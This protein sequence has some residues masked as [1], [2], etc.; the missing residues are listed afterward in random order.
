MKRLL[1]T[2]ILITLVSFGLISCDEPTET[3]HVHTF[4]GE[5]S[6]DENHHWRSSVCGH[7]EEIRAK[8]EHIFDKG[9]VTT[10]PTENS[11]GVK[12]YTCTVC[13]YTKT[14]SISKD[15]MNHEH[16][17]SDSW[18]KDET[19]HWH[20]ATCEHVSKYK[21]KAEHDWDITESDTLI[22]YTCTVCGEVKEEEV[23]IPSDEIIP[24]STITNKLQYIDIEID[25]TYN[26]SSLLSELS[27][28]T[29]SMDD[30]TLAS[31][32]NGVLTG[33]KT[34]V[35]KVTLNHDGK[36]QIVRLE[37]HE[38]GA[39]GSVFT[40]DEYRL[41]GKNIVAFGDSVTDYVTNNA[42]SYYERFADIF[43][44][45]A[46][47]NYAI[48]GTTAHYGYV[49]SNLYNEYFYN[50]SWIT[51]GAGR[52]VVDGP[53]RVKNAYDA[54]E[55]ANIDYV[56][57]AYT[58]NDQHFQP[59]PTHDGYDDYNLNSFD[60]CASF[61]GSYIYMIETLK[62]ANPNVRIILMAPTYA[63][64]DVTGVAHNG[65]NY[66]G[67]EYN[68][69]DYRQ[70]IKEA[71]AETNTKYVNSWNYLKDYFDSHPVNGGSRKYYNDI[72]HLSKTGQQVLAEY[73]A[74][75]MSDWYLQGAFADSATDADYQFSNATSNKVKLNLTITDK[76]LDVPF[77]ISNGST[78][79]NATNLMN[80]E[81]FLTV[82]S[83]NQIAFNAEG[84]YVI[85][86]DSST[87]TIKITKKSDPV[88]YY[89][90]FDSSSSYAKVSAAYLN[91]ETGLYEFD[92]EFIQW[93]SIQINYNGK[94]LSY[95][96]T[97]FQ[98][99]FQTS[100]SGTT[101]SNLYPIQN[102]TTTFVCA[103]LNGGQYTFKYDPKEDTLNIS[104]KAFEEDNSGLTYSGTQKGVAKDNGDGT[105]SF[106]VD[107]P[108]WGS[109]SMKFNNIPLSSAKVQVSGDFT[110]AGATWTEKLYHDGN[111][112]SVFFCCIGEQGNPS[113]TNH[114]KFTYNPTAN[115]LVIEHIE[116]EVAKEGFE[117]VKV[118]NVS[119]FDVKEANGVY[120]ITIVTTEDKNYPGVRLYYN[121][122]ELT[123]KNTNVSGSGYY[124]DWGA[125]N[126]A[127]KVGLYYQPD[128]GQST[129]GWFSIA[130][131]T[132]V[133]VYD[134][135]NNT[136]EITTK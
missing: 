27:G 36:E 13:G 65:D 10:E 25:E 78:N 131:G 24:T 58:H 134:S 108:I 74:N 22:T 35:T 17:Y 126:N 30:T 71:A 59:I 101:S 4:S 7:E 68:Y 96:R 6:S 91:T 99:E 92:V 129:P 135:V 2:L 97:G 28:M 76:E 127:N 32:T 57:I 119:S 114:Y 81:K 16:T 123:N 132:F 113:V 121:G 40:F 107:L 50:G 42:K 64:Y 70:M 1:F 72:V 136:L 100:Y 60:S 128:D 115:T 95:S 53:Q 20:A 110:T 85:E 8:G 18:S 83:D 82:N 11:D 124:A 12:T 5:W 19:Y 47:K 98:G 94:Y 45:N 133:V 122:S 56:F 54:N 43:G 15:D 62:L 51:D 89:T 90:T 41:V 120:T 63:M 112:T 102:K 116:K 75:G 77:T 117:L 38:K 67:K 55:L 14:E 73:L 49:G 66:Y 130:S 33:K 3:E 31:Y 105:Y 79:F 103:N 125:L 39:L 84:E 111:D 109:V 29:L 37:V 9:K 23:N 104:S 44:M 48:G 34:G 87:D 118:Q 106:E 88:I 93:G 21:D 26:I 52:K 69:S 80:Q 46:V 86:L 61:K